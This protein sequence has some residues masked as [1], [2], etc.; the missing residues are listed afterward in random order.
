[1]DNLI[2][3]ISKYIFFL[4]ESTAHKMSQQYP[5]GQSHKSVKDPDSFNAEQTSSGSERRFRLV[6]IL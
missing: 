4:D 2:F 1:M 6:E 5:T 3:V